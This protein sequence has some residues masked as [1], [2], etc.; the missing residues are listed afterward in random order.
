MS[1]HRKDDGSFG[2]GIFTAIVILASF[3]C[4]YALRDS[5]FKVNVDRPPISPQSQEVDR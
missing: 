2:S 5:G 3:V 1:Y 4:G